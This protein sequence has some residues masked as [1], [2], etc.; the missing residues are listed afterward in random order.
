MFCFLQEC[1]P[2]RQLFH[3]EQEPRTQASLSETFSDENL[4]VQRRISP[5]YNQ[6]SADEEAERAAAAQT[7]LTAKYEAEQAKRTQSAE[8]EAQLRIAAAEREA[9]AAMRAAKQDAVNRQRE[10]ETVGNAIIRAAAE[11]EKAQQI[12]DS[13]AEKHEDSFKRQELIQVRAFEQYQQQQK[14]REEVTVRA[15]AVVKE[16][17]EQ[18]LHTT[19]NKE[20][21][22]FDLVRRHQDSLYQQALRENREFDQIRHRGF[23]S[24]QDPEEIRQNDINQQEILRRFPTRRQA[25]A[26]YAEDRANSEFENTGRIGQFFGR[27][28]RQGSLEGQAAVINTVQAL[29]SGMNPLHVAMM[30]STQL[31]GAAIQGG[32]ISLQSIFTALTSTTGIVV[33]GLTA[34]AGAATLAAASW[35]RAENQIARGQNIAALQGRDSAQVGQSIRETS[36]RIRTSGGLG[37][38]ESREAAIAINTI[39]NISTETRESLSRSYEA[40]SRQMFQGDTEETNKFFSSFGDPSKLKELSS[41]LGLIKEGNREAFETAV[42][43]GDGFTSSAMAAQA[44]EE[45]VR[46]TIDQLKQAREQEG[47]I[48]RTFDIFKTRFETILNQNT[49]T[50]SVLNPLAGFREPIFKTGT[51]ALPVEERQANRAA[52]DRLK[53]EGD[54]NGLIRQREQLLRGLQG[55]TTVGQAERFGRGIQEAER[56][57]RTT[58]T[59]LEQ[60]T[61]GVQTALLQAQTTQADQAAQHDISQANKVAEAAKATLDDIVAH[62]QSAAATRLGLTSKLTAERVKAEQDYRNA[63]LQ[64]QR[65]Q[66]EEGLSRRTLTAADRP[67]DISL[68]RQ[69]SESKL[70]DIVRSPASTQ[71]QKDTQLLETVRLRQQETLEAENVNVIDIQKNATLAEAKGDLEQITR[72]RQQ[73]S[74]IIQGSASTGLRGRVEAAQ[75]E[76]RTVQTRISTEQRGVAQEIARI[77]L[78]RAARPQDTELQIASVRQEQAAQ[79]SVPSTSR[80]AELAKE[81]ELITLE[82]QRKIELEDLNIIS[83]TQNGILAEAVGNLKEILNTQ[84]QINSITQSSPDRSEIE[85]ANAATQLR[86]REVGVGQRAL[87]REGQVSGIERAQNPVDLSYQ[88]RSLEEDLNRLRA[89]GLATEEQILSKIQEIVQARR[90]E[91]MEVEDVA[92]GINRQAESILQANENLGGV[93]QLRRQEAALIEASPDRSPADKIQARTQLI[94]SQIQTLSRARQIEI[95]TTD[96]VNQADQRRLQTLSSFSNLQVVSGTARSWNTI[97]AEQ[98]LTTQSTE[99]QAKRLN[100]LMAF[101]DLT[102]SDRARVNE[103][104]AALYEQDAQK[105][106]ELQTRLTQSIREENNRR[107]ENFKNFFSSVESSASDLL[108][109][110][111]NRT[112]TR[113]EAVKNLAQSVVSSFV[114]ETESMASKWAGKG[115]A[116]ILDVK[117]GEGEDSSISTVLAK[118]LG[119]AIGLTKNEPKVDLQTLAGQSMQKAADAQKTASDL[120][121]QAAREMKEAV[122]KISLSPNSPEQ[123]RTP[124]SESERIAIPRSDPALSKSSVVSESKSSITSDNAYG[125]PRGM[126]PVIRTAAEKYGH[127]PDVAVKVARSE[128]LGTFLGDHG[129]SGGAFQLYTGGGLGNEFQ[130][131]TGLSPLD[132]KNEVATIDYAMRNLSRTGWSPYHGARGA[133]ISDRQGIDVGTREAA[134]KVPSEQQTVSLNESKR[135]LGASYAI[136]LDE[137]TLA[138]KPLPPLEGDHK[139]VLPPGTLYNSKGEPYSRDLLTM[140]P[141][142]KARVATSEKSLREGTFWPQARTGLDELQKPPGDSVQTIKVEPASVAQGVAQG[143]QQAATATRSA[144]EQGVST[145]Q[146]DSVSLIQASVQQGVQQGQQQSVSATQQDS[147]QTQTNNNQVQSNSTETQKNTTEITKLTSNIDKLAQQGTQAGDSAVSAST[148]TSQLNSAQSISAPVIYSS[149]YTS[150]KEVGTSDTPASKPAGGIGVGSGLSTLSQGLGLAS[151]AALLFGNHLST[152]GRM[153][154]G[155]VSLLANGFSFLQSVTTLLQ[156][157]NVLNTVA[158]TTNTVATA[159]NTAAQGAGS[160]ASVGSTVAKVAPFALAALEGG[161]IVS[162]ALDGWVVPSAAEGTIIQPIPSAAGGMFVKEQSLPGSILSG[163]QSMARGGQASMFQNA[164][165]VNGPKVADGKGGQFIVAHPGEMIVPRNETKMILDNLGSSGVASAEAGMVLDGRGGTAFSMTASPTVPNL[166]SGIDRTVR[167]AVNNVIST[168]NIDNNSTNNNTTL[169][170]TAHTTGYHPYRTRSDFEGLLREHGSTLMRWA[171]SNFR[172]GSWPQRSF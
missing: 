53:V 77:A 140:P 79:A 118:G 11:R 136:D 6:A 28:N 115:L 44:L 97:P 98:A 157:A 94:Q 35:N 134:N 29:A 110:G 52:E 168:S 147:V 66:L 102:I 32:L 17:A 39:P 14:R 141:E 145:G 38:V 46:P 16:Q 23:Y 27:L 42:N 41:Q 88:R 109:A 80:E 85:K 24:I 86:Q 105:Q 87:A 128:G 111:L 37:R 5:A 47:P 103:Q 119:S 99:T 135:P 161:G 138:R 154:L 122:G 108:I 92:I 139:P 113:Q 170:Y 142:E 64:T 107:I 133:G 163:I 101:G 33:T 100:D 171:E 55:S 132:P 25:L 56:E 30:E 162:S 82:R 144:V 65:L 48:R 126:E 63:V 146:R 9:N 167:E 31:G 131:E 18:E 8:R 71:S 156:G 7:A 117:L 93:V 75:D 106:I 60:E 151:S 22:E 1:Q 34:L 116:S 51:P 159:A 153:V 125:D 49:G 124:L 15:A 10:E 165:M 73:E 61:R 137:Q 148:S 59:P 89:S 91:R 50:T 62:E 121:L 21:R 90:A 36:D 158:T 95:Q 112:Q 155:G 19:A 78:V 70:E 84:R 83:I 12:Y 164:R 3:E 120:M 114:K 169:N 149:T 43:I 104:L 68:Q 4:R 123:L 69:V 172:N 150:D 127:D 72:L 13:E 20:N 152:S 57:I 129:K 54:I 74:A 76:L 96:A 40:V 2:S 26:S 143:Q 166:R 45:R 81:R 67:A 130:K 160:A 58:R